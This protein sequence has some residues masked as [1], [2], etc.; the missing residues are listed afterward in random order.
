VGNATVQPADPGGEPIVVRRAA[1]DIEID[2]RR[3]ADSSMPVRVEASVGI[4]DLEVTVPRW[5]HVYVDAR[6]GRGEVG[7]LLPERIRQGFDQHAAGFSP[8]RPGGVRI[9]IAAE[10]G[11]GSFHVDRFGG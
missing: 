4:G 8:G 5:A 3:V 7:T 10:V 1:G 11:A 2:L 6:V 9:R